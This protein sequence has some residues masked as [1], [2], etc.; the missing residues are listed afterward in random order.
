[1]ENDF[2]TENI[3]IENFAKNQFLNYISGDPYPHI[4]IDNFFDEKILNDI[5]DEFNLNNKN[6]IIFNNPNEKKITLNKWED[7][8]PKTLKFIKF[9]NSEIFIKFL[10]RI[11]LL[12][13]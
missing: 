5:C 7:F 2:Q 4:V 9:L 13:K 12:L 11:L 1:M 10:E 6:K 8:G 3:D